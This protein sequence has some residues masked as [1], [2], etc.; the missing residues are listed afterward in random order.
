MSGMISAGLSRLSAALSTL[1]NKADSGNYTRRSVELDG[2]GCCAI[3]PR[4][5][6]WGAGD[7]SAFAWVDPQTVANAP[8]IFGGLA[9]SFQMR[10]QA[11]GR[12][13]VTKTNVADIGMS[14]AAASGACLVGYTRTGGKG[15]FWING[16]AA[17]QIDDT[18]A[19][20]GDVA[21][22][23]STDGLS[24]KFDGNIAGAFILSVALNQAAVAA[25]VQRQGILTIDQIAYCL[26]GMDDASRYPARVIGPTA[27]T[28]RTTVLPPSVP[29][30]AYP[31][32]MPQDFGLAARTGTDYTLGDSQTWGFNASGNPVYTDTVAQRLLPQYRAT[33][34]YASMSGRQLTPVNLAVTGSGLRF[35][36][37]QPTASTYAWQTQFYSMG[38]VPVTWI[39]SVRMLNGWNDCIGAADMSTERVRLMRRAY[40]ACVARAIIVDYG[41]ISTTGMYRVAPTVVN[42]WACTGTDETLVPPSA[43]CNPFPIAGGSNTA[44]RKIRLAPGQY[45]EFDVLVVQA[46]FIFTENASTGSAYKISVNGVDIL[47]GTTKTTEAD[48]WPQVNAIRN[49]TIGAKMRI[50]CTGGAGEYVTF[51]GVGY[52]GQDTSFAADRTIILGTT[53]GNLNNHTLA[54]LQIVGQQARMAAS[55]FADYGVLFADVAASWQPGDNDGQDLDHISPQGNMRIA[56]AWTAARPVN[57]VAPPWHVDM[58][59]A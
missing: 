24:A 4:V 55:A 7:F 23:G 47:T 48:F 58:A 3:S 34:I 50:T 27:G 56:R 1:G 2:V 39:G 21:F 52:V 51:L 43:A 54:N 40:E 8:G 13:S 11:D 36:P 29:T 25:L 33:E 45:V 14:S 15:T 32:T 35:I 10:M 37:G 44:I 46:K 5:T 49:P 59:K 38:Q 26:Y 41:G 9:G 6:A 22:L 20:T 18:T 12:L 19:Y 57:R 16:G 17:G 53:S 28:S 30:S 31:A 42:G